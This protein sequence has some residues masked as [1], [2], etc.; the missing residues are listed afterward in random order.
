MTTAEF[1][2]GEESLK[3]AL[4]TVPDLRAAQISLGLSVDLKW[5]TGLTYLNVE[6][7]KTGAND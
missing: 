3:K 6:L 1:V 7:G 4:V 5:S 2:M